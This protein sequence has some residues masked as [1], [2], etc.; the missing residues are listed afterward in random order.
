M[1]HKWC[2]VLI[3]DD[4]LLIRQGIKHSIDWE[5]E[6]FK[7]IGEASNGKEALDLIKEKQP[8]IVITDMVMPVMD[9]EQLTKLI[10]KDYPTIEIIILSSFSDYDYV[11]AT[12]Q[13]GVSDYILKPQLEGGILLQSLRQAVDRMPHFTLSPKN[14]DDE[15]TQ[16]NQMIEKSMMGYEVDEYLSKIDEFFPHE[17]YCLL[18]IDCKN[19]LTSAKNNTEILERKIEE[20][21]EKT[22][23]HIVAHKILTVEN[24]IIFLCNFKP[25]QFSVIKQFVKETSISIDLENTELG[26]VLTKSFSHFDRLKEIYD[27]HLLSLLNYRFYLPQMKVVIYDE[28]AK[29]KV[30]HEPFQLA[31]FTNLFKRK[32]FEEA[33]DYLDRH[34]HQLVDQYITDE[35]SFKSFLGN[36]IFNITVLLGNMDY[37]NKEL[38][39]EKM[40]YI[41]GIDESLHANNAL[42][43]FKDFLER[44]TNVI[45]TQATEFY[46]PKMQELL[47][48]IDQHYAEPLNLS[49]IADKFHYNP[50]YLSS[51]FSENNNLSFIEYVNKVRIEKSIELLEEG[52]ESIAEISLLVGYSDHSY[53]GKVFRNF[54]GTSPS[55]YRRQYYQARKKN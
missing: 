37:D 12:F 26:W 51:F 8:H 49:D 45:A 40:T 36:I 22:F 33:F 41:I 30:I 23:S 44:V 17:D 16:I 52:T 28:L 3:V 1:A 18:A 5:A 25:S 27:D 55:K 4:E 43:L 53:F 46:H 19:R 10:K 11:R 13:Q 21:I 42:D 29:I 48:Y 54:I 31:Q 38:E 35:F 39:Q 50:S 9:G 14:I 32:Q 7:I 24:T 34:I 2:K 47:D 6:G 20:K 15:Q